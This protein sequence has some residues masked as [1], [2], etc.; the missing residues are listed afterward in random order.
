M[1]DLLDL[2]EEPYDEKR[3]VVCFDETPVQLVEDIVA[4]ISARPGCAKKQDYEY[5]RNGSC[6]AFLFL[7]P[8]GGWRDIRVTEHRKKA[9]FAVCMKALVDEYFPQADK[10]RLVMDNLNIHTLANLYHVYPPEEAR[11]IVKKIE[12]HYT[13]KHGSWLN[14]A[15]IEFSVLGRQCLRKRIGSIEQLS[16]ETE[17]FVSERNERKARVTWGFFTEQARK[18]MKWLYNN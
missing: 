13:P 4:P 18:K 6:N 2:Y 1:E 16:R 10:I 14:M 15:E 11:R 9:D 12:V 7:Q 5:Q 8:L 17:V 3:P